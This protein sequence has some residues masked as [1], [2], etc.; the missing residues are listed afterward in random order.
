MSPVFPALLGCAL[1]PVVSPPR[2]LPRCSGKPGPV[3]VFVTADESIAPLRSV[4]QA[5]VHVRPSSDVRTL[6]VSLSAIGRV[7]VLDGPVVLDDVRGGAERV[8]PI[9]FLVRA[10]GEGEVRATITGQRADGAALGSTSAVLYLLAARH[11]VL[12]ARTGFLDLRVA[13]L[14]RQL[15]TR[16]LDGARHAAAVESLRGGGL[17]VRPASAPPAVS[18]L[19]NVSGHVLW[20]DRSGGTHPVRFAPVQILDARPALA[21]LAVTSTDLSGRFEVR[22]PWGVPFIVRV[23]AQGPGF[24]VRSEDGVVQHVDTFPQTLT[25]RTTSTTTTPPSRSRTV[26]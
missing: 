1:L 9:R 26:S 6:T 13:R 17:V 15:Q 11:E 16:V 22:V 24:A 21:R 3:Q 20:T 23:L 4:V 5:K 19:G 14:D 12:F 2:P 25:R 10:E 8:V 7:D 18:R